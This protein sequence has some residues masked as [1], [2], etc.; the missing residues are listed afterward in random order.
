MRSLGVRATAG[1]PEPGPDNG[2]GDDSLVLGDDKLKGIARF[3]EGI[4]HHET[5]VGKYRLY[6]R[7]RDGLLR[8]HAD[9]RLPIATYEHVILDEHAAYRTFKANSIPKTT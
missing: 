2:L 4:H 8:R 3:Q 7:T 1:L 9:L 6:T 5:D